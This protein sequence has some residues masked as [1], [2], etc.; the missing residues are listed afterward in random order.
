MLSRAPERR[1]LERAA[2]AMRSHSVIDL[3]SRVGPRAVEVGV[4]SGRTRA[5]LGARSSPRYRRWRAGATVSGDPTAGGRECQTL[6]STGACPFGIRLRAR[7]G[8]QVVGNA[9]VSPQV[10]CLGFG[11]V[12]V[13]RA[14]EFVHM[15][16]A[17]GRIRTCARGSEGRCIVWR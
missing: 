9:P 15:T 10:R 5:V 8:H 12:K 4:L 6:A 7:I 2:S 1:L 13:V 3:A 14:L 16:S 17:P 11:C